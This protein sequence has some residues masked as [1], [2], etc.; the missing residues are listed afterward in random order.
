[1]SQYARWRARLARLFSWR[2]GHSGACKPANSDMK[3]IVVVEGV[4]DIAFLRGIS[5]MLHAHEPDLPD[6]GAMEHR[7]QLVFVPWGGVDLMQWTHRLAPLAKPEFHVCD[8][9]ASPETEL[10]WQYASVVNSRLGCCAVVTSKRSME[11]YVHPAAIREADG[12]DVEFG[13]DDDVADLIARSRYARDYPDE[14]WDE[15]PRRAKTRR[16]NRVKRWL[17]R[18][19]VERMTPQR[20]AEQDPQGEV[21]SWLEMML[22]LIHDSR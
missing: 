3:L 14:S 1:M 11:N 22:G 18:A 7:G 9:E 17:N 13:N 15:L 6:L 19:A 10:R 5:A 8:R 4:H 16:R 20:L 12:V 21:R 2:P